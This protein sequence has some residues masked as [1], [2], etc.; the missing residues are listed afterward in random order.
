MVQYNVHKNYYLTEYKHLLLEKNLF[1]FVQGYFAL[2]T[3][4]IYVTTD[5]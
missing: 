4:V 3:V 2:S 5:K 1:F